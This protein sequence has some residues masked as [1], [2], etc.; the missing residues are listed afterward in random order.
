MK[1]LRQCSMK[2]QNTWQ[3]HV[4]NVDIPCYCFSSSLINH[5][6]YLQTL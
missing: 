1:E 4:P 2:S 6:T 3:G 5:S